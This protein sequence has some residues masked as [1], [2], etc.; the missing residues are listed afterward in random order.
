MSKEN[1]NYEN[2]KKGNLTEDLI[3]QLTP[4]ILE[5]ALKLTKNKI[6]T[7]HN[8][9]KVEQEQDERIKYQPIIN[10]IDFI[11]KSEAPIDAINYG[12]KKRQIIEVSDINYFEDYIKI[13]IDYKWNIDKKNI[14]DYYINIQ[15]INNLIS[16]I[17]EETG[18]FIRPLKP[19]QNY[20]GFLTTDLIILINPYM[21]KRKEA[22][23]NKDN[24]KRNYE[25][26]IKELEK[27]ERKYNIKTNPYYKKEQK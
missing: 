24:D 16:Y 17:G 12:I 11:L 9:S 5:Q 22:I 2:L 3:N 6:L 15:K 7:K 8:K 18:N 25:L 13:I 26:Y 27:L 4:E 1:E 21:L 10:G 14:K 20:N 23:M 19:K